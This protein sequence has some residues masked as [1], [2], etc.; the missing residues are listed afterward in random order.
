MQG[1]S[2]LP[3]KLVREWLNGNPNVKIT[4][5]SITVTEAIFNDTA[6]APPQHHL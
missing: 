5:Q 6:F 4:K 1:M 3:N 2:N